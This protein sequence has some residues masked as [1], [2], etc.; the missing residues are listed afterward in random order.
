MEM[1]SLQDLFVDTLKDTYDAEHQITKALPKLAKA[2]NDP[3]LK[4]AFE[5]HLKQTENHIK[6][7][8]QVFE[9]QGMKAGRKTCNGMKGLLEEG[10]EIMKEDS[11]PQVLDPALI[12]A[13]QKVEHYEMAAYGTLMAYAKQIDAMDA[14]RLLQ[15]TLSEEKQADEK[16]T[17]LAESSINMKAA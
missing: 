17:R 4:T 3:K 9:M 11:K 7:L 10:S 6:R 1:K 14:I 15:Q 12:A 2:A 13:A 8:E 16:L 5:E